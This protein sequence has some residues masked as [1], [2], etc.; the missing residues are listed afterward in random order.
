MKTQ[1]PELWGTAK[2]VLRGKF[3]AISIYIKKSE[4]SSNNLP[5]YF[6]L[7]E[8]QE[9]A[10]TKSSRGKEITKIRAEIN[11]METNRTRQKKN[12][13]KSWLFE[14]MNKIDK[15]LERRKR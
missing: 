9:Q 3:I 2:T 8:K 12:E 15:T 13:T 1:L 5:L 7:L 14:K 11:E 6:K 4:S 10:K